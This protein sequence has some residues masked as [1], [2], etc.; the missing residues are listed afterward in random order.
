MHVLFQRYSISA[1]LDL[2][3]IQ[4]AIDANTTGIVQFQLMGT[5][6]ETGGAA[7]Q[8]ADSLSSESSRL[9]SR[10]QSRLP[11]PHFAGKAELQK[12]MWH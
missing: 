8:A 5:L 4:L 11:A 7:F 12:T 9:E 2:G 1:L 6:V 3:I 10:Q